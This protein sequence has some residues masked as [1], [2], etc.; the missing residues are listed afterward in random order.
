MR[1][2]GLQLGKRWVHIAREAE[3]T[4]S[5]LG[6]IRRGEYKPS[7]HTAA[8]LDEVLGWEPGSVEAILAGGEATVREQR[9]PIGQAV[10][11]GEAEPVIPD[12]LASLPDDPA[13]RV[14]ELTRR[15]ERRVQET[16]QIAEELARLT[17]HDRHADTG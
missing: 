3:I 4:T 1:R 10:E 5:A 6:A 16:R 2:R 8:A 11:T 12:P 13:E 14:A 9:V 7:P 17:G 15:I